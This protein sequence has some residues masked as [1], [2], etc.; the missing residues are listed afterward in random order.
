MKKRTG[1]L[2][3]HEV[4][5]RKRNKLQD[6]TNTDGFFRML[7]NIIIRPA[8]FF[9][10]T[11]A[12]EGFKKPIKFL[13]FNQLILGG[14]IALLIF[15]IGLMVALL[16]P[17][18][19]IP[20]FMIMILIAVLTLISSIAMPLVFSFASALL[21]HLFA[22]LLGGRGNFQQAYKAT[23]YSFA[24][25]IPGIILYFLTLGLAGTFVWIYSLVLKCL[26]V[27]HYY[28]LTEDR[29]IGV[30]AL[31]FLLI[32]FIGMIFFIAYV[33]FVIA[34]SAALH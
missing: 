12:D 3:V 31:Y 29:A 23:V 15:S 28:D 14:M 20:I 8:E 6:E 25:Q 21:L 32:M 27:Y 34:M 7:W 13:V 5:G 17:R 10:S 1:Q 22:K 18:E 4:Y 30:G 19:G 9:R 24:V 2:K 11:A 16:S 33:L 26:A